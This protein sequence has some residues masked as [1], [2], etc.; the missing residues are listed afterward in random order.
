MFPEGDAV[1]R[2]QPGSAQGHARAFCSR[3]RCSCA[4]VVAQPLLEIY[5]CMLAIVGHCQGMLLLIAAAGRR[6]DVQGCQGSGCGDS[7]L[8]V[9]HKRG[10]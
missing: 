7:G 10:D 9:G 3:E 2:Q 1:P 5:P 8:P 6:H 4:F